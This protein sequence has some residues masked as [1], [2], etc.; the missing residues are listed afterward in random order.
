M[1]NTTLIN[2]EVINGIGTL[3]DVRQ[4]STSSVSFNNFG[5]NDGNAY[6]VYALDYDS[7]PVIDVDMFDNPAGNGT[8]VVNSYSRVRGVS[9]GIHIKGNSQIQ[10]EERIDDLKRNLRLVN[11]DLDVVRADGTRFRAI[12]RVKNTDSAFDR[13]NR[14]RDKTNVRLE[15]E[16]ANG[17]F[18]SIGYQSMSPISITTS[19]YEDLGV[20]NDGVY[21]S[22]L[23]C[24]LVFSAVNTCTKVVVTNNTTG[25]TMT[26]DMG[27]QKAS[28]PTSFAVGD[29]LIIDSENYEV[30][31]TSSVNVLNNQLLRPQ[32]S[33]LSLK[34]PQGTFNG[35]NSIDITTT[36][37]SHTILFTT[38]HKT[39]I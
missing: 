17:F 25:Q 16:V 24:N 26:V 39:R 6:T 19:P 1:I 10:L 38:Q 4:T 23:N 33:F 29:V 8:T 20:T 2:I 12:A 32:G 21:D 18:E 37:T 3:F 9:M 35:T 14:R 13:P 5:L 15:F 31:L 36:S 27:N 30:R 22:F 28:L 11:G 34:A 7:M